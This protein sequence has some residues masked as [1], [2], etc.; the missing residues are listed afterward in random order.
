MRSRKA[1]V[2]HGAQELSSTARQRGPL[3]DEQLTDFETSGELIE[4]IDELYRLYRSVSSSGGESLFFL[5]FFFFFVV[6]FFFFSSWE[7]GV[8]VRPVR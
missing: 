7:G 8:Q 1:E 3:R 6:V 5:F 4:M 2:P